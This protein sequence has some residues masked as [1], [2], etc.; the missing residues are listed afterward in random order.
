VNTSVLVPVA[1]APITAFTGIATY[2]AS[3]G[4]Q[5]PKRVRII[6]LATKRLQF[7]DQLLHLQLAAAE[8]DSPE[9]SQAKAEA[10]TAI[11][12]IRSD[13]SLELKRLSRGQQ[14]KVLTSRQGI[15]QD[16]L[17]VPGNSLAGQQKAKYW[18]W[19][20]LFWAYIITGT[21]LCARNLEPFRWSGIVVAF[22]LSIFAGFSRRWAEEVRYPKPEAPIID[23]I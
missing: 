15:L 8:P 12:K 10:L 9:Q 22:I 14:M 11:E 17:G 13:A 1:V 18:F 20:L 5:H 21:L 16:L 6:D 2:V 7:W 23:E 19:M 3:Y 4:G